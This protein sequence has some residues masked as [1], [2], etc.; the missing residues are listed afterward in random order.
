MCLA[1]AFIPNRTPAACTF[2]YMCPLVFN[3]CQPISATSKCR[4]WISRTH[5]ESPFLS[6]RE[7]WLRLSAFCWRRLH[8]CVKW[9][10]MCVGARFFFAVLLTGF[11]LARWKASGAWESNCFCGGGWNAAVG[12]LFVFAAPSWEAA[13]LSKV[14]EFVTGN[15]A[16]WNKNTPYFEL[17][18][19]FQR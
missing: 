12:V 19:L 5:P 15:V 2:L 6:L 1:A 14:M 18:S 10:R 3:I 4:R 7:C 11:L 17:G 9:T 8:V 16:I 13:D